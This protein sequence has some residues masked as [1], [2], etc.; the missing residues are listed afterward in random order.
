MRRQKRMCFA[1]LPGQCGGWNGSDQLR[2]LGPLE[3]PSS[4]TC[5][6]KRLRVP[7]GAAAGEVLQ[8][9]HV[10]ELLRVEGSVPVSSCRLF[11][12]WAS[13]C[14]LFLHVISFWAPPRLASCRG[15]GW[16][17]A[18]LFCLLVSRSSLVLKKKNHQKVPALVFSSFSIDGLA[19]GTAD[20]PE[21]ATNWDSFAHAMPRLE[22]RIF[23][24]TGLDHVMQACRAPPRQISANAEKVGCS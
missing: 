22:D 16:Q 1:G 23:G 8:P 20:G 3:V 11:C 19:N 9:E 15:C 2:L 4:I 24:Q 21:I 13:A 5:R 10:I 14:D 7:F 12:W 6:V 18:F 17:D